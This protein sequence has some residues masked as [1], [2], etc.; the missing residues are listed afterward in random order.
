MRNKLICVPHPIIFLSLFLY[1]F[2]FFFFAF[3]W[4]IADNNVVIVSDEQ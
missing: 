4:G 3:Y 2:F 1:F